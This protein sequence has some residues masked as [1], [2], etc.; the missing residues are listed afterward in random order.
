[1]HY[2]QSAPNKSD[3]KFGLRWLRPIPSPDVIEETKAL[4]HVHSVQTFQNSQKPKTI[5]V[6]RK[7]Y[8]FRVVSEVFFL[9]RNRK[10]CSS[11]IYSIIQV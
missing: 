6:S 9:S 3:C 7:I 5:H 4:S 10:Q 11:T 1:M 8:H 2:I